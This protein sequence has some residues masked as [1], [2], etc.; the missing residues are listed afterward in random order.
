MYI[1][2]R[3]HQDNGRWKI[4]QGHSPS[5][6]HPSYTNAQDEAQR[7][8]TL[9]PGAYFGIFEFDKAATCSVTPVDWIKL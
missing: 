4:V 2:V 9:N 8:S 5:A 6:I 7:L 3:I 1:I